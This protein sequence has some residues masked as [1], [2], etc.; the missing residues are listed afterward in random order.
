M[1]VKLG[2]LGAGGRMG[3][4]IIATIAHTPGATLGGAVEAADHPCVG[5]PLTG[6]LVI[7]SNAGALAHACDVL[8]DFT[9]PAALATNLE[10]ACGSRHAIVV[11]TTGLTAAHHR[12]IDDAARHVAVLQA[13]NTS[14]GVAVLAALVE[15]AAARLPAWAA[16]ILELHHG[17]KTDAPSGTALVLGEAV[18]RGRGQSAPVPKASRA[19]TRGAKE[20]GFA[21]LRGG[22]AAGDH[23][24]FL[25]GSYERLELTHRAESRAVFAQGAVAA[26]LWLKGRAPGRYTMENL[27]G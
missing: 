9:A 2:V 24:V 26:A 25:L 5:Q 15:Q 6:G 7:C 27:I 23:T 21:S 11:G 13:A 16:E 19:G 3:R 1:G 10:A 18:A 22:T 20:I 17:D 8:I 14:L 12:L 4:E